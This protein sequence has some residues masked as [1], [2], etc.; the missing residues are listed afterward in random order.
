MLNMLKPIKKCKTC[1]MELHVYLGED[2]I[3]HKEKEF[4]D[5][6]CKTAWQ[7][8]SKYI[9]E[10]RLKAETQVIIEELSPDKTLPKIDIRL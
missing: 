2:Y 5:E 7:K 4:C 1:Q 10:D 9:L 6:L 3:I 8:Y